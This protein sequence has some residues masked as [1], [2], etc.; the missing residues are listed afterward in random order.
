M[1]S[2][3]DHAANACIYAAYGGVLVIGL[4]AVWYG[5]GKGQYLASN[6][7]RSAFPLTFNFIASGKY[8]STFSQGYRSLLSQSGL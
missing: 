6:R 8:S 3:S 7:K 5:R 2:L 1:G 4:F